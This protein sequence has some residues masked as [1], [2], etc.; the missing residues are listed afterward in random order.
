M[1]EISLSEPYSVDEIGELLG[2]DAKLRNGIRLHFGDP[3]SIN[4]LKRITRRDFMNCKGLGFKSWYQF[5]TGLSEFYTSH[6]AVTLINKPS[7]GR[8][9][10]EI[11][12]ARPFGEVE[13]KES[14]DKINKKS[15]YQLT[16]ERLI[17]IFFW[18]GR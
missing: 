1:K 11:E 8:I 6:S 17:L 10:M 3:L 7:T 15:T 9:I 12:T 16:G 4:D 13:I 14:K 2:F 18:S 5:Y